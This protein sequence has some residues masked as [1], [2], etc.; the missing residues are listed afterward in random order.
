[1]RQ[2]KPIETTWDTIFRNQVGFLFEEDNRVIGTTFFA[3]KLTGT[4]PSTRSYIFLAGRNPR[5]CE[6]AR[7]VLSGA[8]AIS[9]LPYTRYGHFTSYALIY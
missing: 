7:H 1:M 8:Y 4:K 6:K 5:H 2:K 9:G 3:P